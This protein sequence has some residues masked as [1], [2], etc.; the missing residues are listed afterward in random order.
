MAEKANEQISKPQDKEIT[1]SM[2]ENYQ[3]EIKQ[4]E[5]ALKDKI[6]GKERFS[7]QW[8]RDKRIWEIKL[9]GA[10]KITPTFEY[11]TNPEYWELIRSVIEDQVTQ[12]TYMSEK[13]LEHYDVEI[14]SLQEQIDSNKE[15]LAKLQE[16]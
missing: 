13:K 6:A 12:D 8:D 2:I 7:K 11:E 10:K 5:Q 1:Q 9:E 4:F 15:A 14:E 16:E 3:T